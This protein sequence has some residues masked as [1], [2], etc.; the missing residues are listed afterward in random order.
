VDAIVARLRLEQDDV[1]GALAAAS[2]TDAPAGTDGHRLQMEA[3]AHCLLAAGRP[4]EALAVLDGERLVMP[5]V[6]NPGWRFAS[7]VRARALAASDRSDEALGLLKAQIELARRW[8]APSTIGRLLLVQGRLAGPEGTSSLEEA[9]ALLAASPTRLEHGKALA[10]LGAARSGSHPGEA[11]VLLR[12][13]LDIADDCGGRR[14]RKIVAAQ[15]AAIGEVVP[16]EPHD[17]AAA[18]TTTER[19]IVTLADEGAD[20]REI[21]QALFVTPGSVERHLAEARRKLT[22]R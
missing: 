8:G 4:A 14:L 2:V 10:A 17:G 21:A 6:V 1:D 22:V 18:L 12:R 9:E 15:L 11:R 13:A 3:K 19:R 5:H 7:D 16:G 20:P